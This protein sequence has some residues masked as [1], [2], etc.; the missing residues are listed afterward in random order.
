MTHN[1]NK[2]T[3]LDKITVKSRIITAI[4]LTGFL[5]TV[6]SLC[7]F[8]YQYESKLFNEK[9]QQLMYLTESAINVAKMYSQQAKDGQITVKEA[10]E[11]TK[12]TVHNMLYDDGNYIWINDYNGIMLEHIKEDLVGVDFKEVKDKK[13]YKFIPVLIEGVKSDGI[14]L[15]EYWWTRGSD[16]KLYPKLSVARGFDEWQWMFASGVYI[17]DVK[18]TVNKTIF[19]IVILC[20][21]IL[22]ALSFIAYIT[23]GKSIINPIEKLTELSLKLADNDLTVTIPEDKN[24]TEIGDLNRSFKTLHSNLKGLIEQVSRSVEEVAS[25]SQQVSAATEQTA[26][27]SQQVAE[28]VTQLAQGSQEQA[29]SVS[30]CLDNLNSINDSVK[31]ISDIANNTVDVSKQTQNSANDGIKKAEDA[32]NKINQIKDTSAEIAGTINTLGQLSADIEQI[33]ELIKNIASQTNLLALNAAI[34]A[35]RAGEHG[36]GFAVVADEVKKLAGES[37]DA[38]DKITEM[39]HEIQAK[40]NSA[41]TMMAD[42]VTEV[43]SGVKSVEGTGESLKEII[44]A[45]ASTT[46]Q[47]QGIATDVESLATNAENVVNLMEGISTVTEEAA[48]SNEEI[49]SI[50]EEQSA[51]L[52]EIGAS[53]QT[54]AK[55]A[56]ELQHQVAKFRI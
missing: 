39:V 50:S 40:T 23:L 20:S 54:L 31:S 34:E 2:S 41:V 49:S 27:G 56:E 14:G 13:G 48:A 21:L 32:V 38:T 52:E 55:I 42:G 45:V 26:Q 11:K 28:S 3:F 44:K 6:L 37:A 9:K 12:Q 15:T 47:V 24:N 30:N 16:T 5:I 46:K 33:V 22:V 4:V 7:M 43:E 35:A 8:S 53:T 25:G 51:S 17:D 36:K 29:N 1:T 18:E 19:N 10:K